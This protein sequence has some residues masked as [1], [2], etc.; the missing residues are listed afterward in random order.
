MY[1][2]TKFAVHAISEAIRR[3]LHDE[4]IRVL[5]ITPGWVDTNLGREVADEEIREKFQRR[6]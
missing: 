4:N 2:G 3:E 5:G 1:S 6:Q